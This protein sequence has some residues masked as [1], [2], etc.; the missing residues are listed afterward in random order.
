MIFY[1][2]KLAFE[3]IRHSPRITL[4][5]VLAIALGIAVATS[6]ATVHHVFAR[7]PIPQKSEAIFNVRIDAWDPNAQFFNVDPGEPPKSVTWRDMTGLMQDGISLRR[8]G[9][10]NAGAY[11]FP[12]DGDL[13]PWQAS[14]RLAH[15][16][17]FPLFLIPFRYGTGWT[18][19]EDR[20]VAPVVVLSSRTND[21][22]FGG[23][24]SV[25]EWVRLGEREYR[26]VGV[27]DNF[28]PTPMYY[29]PINSLSGPP[30]EFFIPFDHIL[31][32]DS[33]LSLRG[34]TDMWGDFRGLAP[35]EF[36]TTAEFFW[37]QYWVELS[38]GTLE[39]YSSFVEGYVLE[40]KKSGRHPKPVNNRVT[41]IMEWVNDR[42][43]RVQGTTKSISLISYFFLA[44]CAVNLMGLLLGKFLSR[45][46]R[47]GIH[48]ALGASR[49][50][51]FIQHVVECEMIGILGGLTGLILTIPALKGIANLIPNARNVLDPG[52]FRLDLSMVMLSVGLS[53][54]AG[55]IAGL[56]PAW[57]ACRV[58]PAI[59]LKL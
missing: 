46:S 48:R 15:A 31:D 13:K 33:G 4:I 37:I 27:L 8:T 12:K 35:R 40:Q 28:N 45:S 52:I 36:V 56:Y 18:E 1:Y 43:V 41:P 42:N 23:R 7:N 59:Q 58:S 17:F 16:D 3:S 14:V 44:V 34:D 47:I 54:L 32:T 10:A 22:L 39:E 21:K 50:T 51:I 19:K 5:S 2:L 9:V 25:G 49:R 26:V 24:D 6:M 53:L 11:L 38:P 57:R 29:D 20:D 30:R 55:L